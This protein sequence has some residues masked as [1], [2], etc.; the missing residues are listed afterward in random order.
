MVARV[1]IDILKKVM[2][3]FFFLGPRDELYCFC[4]KVSVYVF[5]IVATTAFKASLVCLIQTRAARNCLRNM[6]AVR[7]PFVNSKLVDT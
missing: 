1:L 3:F 5:V 6:W 4:Y 7:S 2:F